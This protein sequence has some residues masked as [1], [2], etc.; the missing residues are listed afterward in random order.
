MSSNSHSP[1]PRPLRRRVVRNSPLF[2]G[3]ASSAASRL[4]PRALVGGFT[5]VELLVVIAIIGILIALLLP[6][7]QQAREAARRMQCANHLKQIALAAHGY[8]DIHGQLPPSGIV[9]AKTQIYGSHV[10][11]VFD[12]QSGKMFSWAMLLLPFVEET[13]LYNQFDQSRTVLDQP[14]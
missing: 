10:Y 6:A 14:N 3:Q 1:L 2:R 9:A 12:Q 8:T 13:N 4:A 5:L 7:I 11:P